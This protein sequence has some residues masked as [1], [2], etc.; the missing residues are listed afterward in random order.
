MK[1]IL[2]FLV[3]L[4]ATVSI[5]SAQTTPKFNYQAVVRDVTND[6]NLLMYTDCQVEVKV[7]KVGETETLYEENL[8]G[9]TNRNGMISLI[10]GEN[11][12]KGQLDTIDWSEAYIQATFTANEK[13]VSTVQTPITAVP[14]AIHAKNTPREITTQQIV[15]YLSSPTTTP[16]DLKAIEQALVDNPNGVKQYLKDTVYNYIKAHKGD[17]KALALY[18][19]TQ[20]DE[21][22]LNDANNAVSPEVKNKVKQLIK[23]YAKSDAGKEIAVDVLKY[24]VSNATLQDAQ[25]LWFAVRNNPNFNTV[26][27]A[28]KDSV[29]HYIETHEQLLVDI[30]LHYI[31][32]AT[33]DQVTRVYNYLKTNKPEAYN[34]LLGKFEN[35]LNYYLSNVYHAVSDACNGPERIDICELQA[36]VNQII[37]TDCD[38]FESF[39]VSTSGFAITATVTLNSAATFD[40]TEFEFF[41]TEGGSDALNTIVATP[42]TG[43]DGEFTLDIPTGVTV[44]KYVAKW[45][46]MCVKEQ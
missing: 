35:Y 12:T 32:N 28:V 1:K 33:A 46:G 22:D 25:D 20:V 15:D 39:S 17:V 11:P 21:Q 45:R 30:G 16:D 7:Y 9:T 37:D 27:N 18:F 10:I 41:Y 31:D 23:Q 43:N 4:F 5:L 14:Y 42:V 24:Y 34:F 38:D 3:M 6:H 2:T 44:D 26:F 13:V 29:I 40:A 19:L 36:Q 8:S